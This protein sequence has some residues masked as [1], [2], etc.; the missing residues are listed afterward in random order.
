MSSSVFHGV[1]LRQSSWQEAASAGFRTV[2]SV[3]MSWSTSCSFTDLRWSLIGYRF[4]DEVLTVN[5][6]PLKLLLINTI[7]SVR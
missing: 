3:S 4:C 2:P 1:Y 5:A 6:N 7:R